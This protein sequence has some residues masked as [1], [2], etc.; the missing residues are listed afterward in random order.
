MILLADDV[1]NVVLCEEMK[2]SLRHLR[3]SWD[4]GRSF[5]A[6]PRSMVVASSSLESG[7]RPSD[8]QSQTGVLRLMCD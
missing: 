4:R 1:D 5:T 7:N 3:P 6:L 2:H 8:V